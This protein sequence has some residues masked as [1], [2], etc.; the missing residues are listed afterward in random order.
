MKCDKITT[1][2]NVQAIHGLRLQKVPHT[3]Y[4][5]ANAEFIIPHPNDGKNHDDLDAAEKY[6]TM[7]NALD[8]ETMEVAWQVIVDGNLDNTDADYTGKYAACHL[9]QL[10]EVP[11]ISAGTMRNERDWVV[12]FN[13]PRHRGG[14]QGQAVHD[15]WRLQGAGGRRPRRTSRTAWSPATSRCRRTRTA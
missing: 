13:I 4:V 2:P 3:K 14:N 11:P 15:H 8:A 6:W 1:I 7:F 5:F 10:R 9:L 12:V